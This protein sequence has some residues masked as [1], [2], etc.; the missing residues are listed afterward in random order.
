MDFVLDSIP[1]PLGSKRK[2]Y[3]LGS[4][5]WFSYIFMKIA[6]DV[7]D[8]LI[9]PAVAT[10]MPSDT[11][12]YDVIAILKWFQKQGHTIIVWSG[13]GVDYAKRWAE[14]LALEPCEIR[15]KE[16]SPDIDIAFDDCMVDLA[17]VNIKVNRYN[18]SISRKEWN[19]HNEKT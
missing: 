12:N 11:P 4:V 5:D 2:H 15:I 10:N 18:N 7:D 9:I 19:K 17:K 1:L 8:T 14:K 13:G 3:I 6:F 16:K